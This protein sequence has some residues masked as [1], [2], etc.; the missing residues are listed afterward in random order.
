MGHRQR[1]VGRRRAKESLPPAPLAAGGPQA[2]AKPPG[3]PPLRNESNH[4]KIKQFSSPGSENNAPIP[5]PA[6]G[7]RGGGR[8]FVNSI[9]NAP[10]RRI[11][12]VLLSLLK[13]LLLLSSSQNFLR[14]KTHRF[15]SF[16]LRLLLLETTTLPSVPRSASTHCLCFARPLYASCGSCLEYDQMKMTSRNGLIFFKRGG[17]GREGFLVVVPRVCEKNQPIRRGRRAN[18]PAPIHFSPGRPGGGGNIQKRIL[19]PSL[20]FDCFLVLLLLF[21]LSHTFFFFC[22]FCFFFFFFFFFFFL[23]LCF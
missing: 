8:Q 10:R 6:G 11:P 20:P 23:F 18:R 16:K 1:E 12:R 22:V 3:F 21:I 17:A 9:I 5:S 2:R 13:S 4:Q 14:F 7:G 15:Q 19:P